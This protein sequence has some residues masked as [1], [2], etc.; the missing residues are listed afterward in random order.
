MNQVSVLSNVMNILHVYA[1][2][3]NFLVPFSL[4]QSPMLSQ[5]EEAWLVFFFFQFLAE[6]PLFSCHPSYKIPFFNFLLYLLYL[7]ICADSIIFFPH[8]IDIL[9]AP[10]C[11]SLDE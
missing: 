10:V 9:S 8:L 2:G 1:N 5:F 4:N 3:L 7:N 11:A 6:L